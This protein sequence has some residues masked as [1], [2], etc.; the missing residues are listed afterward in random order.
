[1]FCFSFSCSFLTLILF[2]PMIASIHTAQTLLL[3]RTDA[4]PSIHRI[5]DMNQYSKF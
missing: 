5:L 2:S 1:L 3:I 4:P